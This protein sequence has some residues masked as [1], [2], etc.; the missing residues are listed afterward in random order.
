MNFYNGYQQ[1]TEV[2]IEIALNKL[3]LIY[4]HSALSTEEKLITKDL[5][6]YGLI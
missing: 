1:Y 6:G 2:Y 4:F 3:S 5:S